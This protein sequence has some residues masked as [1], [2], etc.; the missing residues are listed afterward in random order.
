MKQT[1]KD[2]QPGDNVILS[3][4][5]GEDLIV[6]IKRITPTQIIIEKKSLTGQKYDAKYKRTDNDFGV[7]IGEEGFRSTHIRI[8]TPQWLDIIEQKTLFV[9]IKQ[10]I[11]EMRKTE[12]PI[13]T[14]K[15]IWGLIEEK[16]E[17]DE[18]EVVS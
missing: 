5:F 15:T 1:L 11:Q 10:K 7:R 17:S 16:E 14:L 18:D 9:K 3:E 6:P 2:L 13:A 4:H 12:L 8:I